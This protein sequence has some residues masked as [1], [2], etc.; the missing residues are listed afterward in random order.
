MLRFKEVLVPFF[1]G[2]SF[3]CWRCSF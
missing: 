1:A 2:F 3:W